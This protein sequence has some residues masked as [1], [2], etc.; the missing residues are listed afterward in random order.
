MVLRQ[1]YPI[2]VF[3]PALSAQDRGVEDFRVEVTAGWWLRDTRGTIQSGIAPVDLRGDLDIAQDEPQFTGRLVFKPAARHR[4]IFEGSPF[5]LRG[6]AEVNRQF[7]FGGEQFTLR[8]RVV[9]TAD[10]TYIFGGYQFDLF[11]GGHG[12]VGLQG[13]VGYVD[14]TG[15]LQSETFGF[16]GSETQSFPF[17]LVGAEFRALPLGTPLVQIGG[18]LRGASLLDYGHYVEGWLDAGI[19]IGRHVTV[20]AGYRVVDSEVHRRD[21]TRGFVP[22][23]SGP[24]FSVQFRH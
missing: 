19:G 23:F 21:Q 20:L 8:D 16:T 3:V 2:V 9:S 13:G 24:V 12:H 10:I 6:T 22:R 1:L 11:T 4:L 7:T 5:R 15:T 18:G 17:P 14:A